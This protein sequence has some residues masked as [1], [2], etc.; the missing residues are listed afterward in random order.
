MNNRLL[1]VISS[2]SGGGKTTICKKLLSESASPLYGNLRF[3]ISATTRKMRTGEVDGEDYHFL[4]L[5]E[6]NKKLE[7]GEFIEHA[8]VF[9][10][11]YGTLLSEVNCKEHVIFDIDVAGF[12]QIREKIA[13]V[14]VFLMP[15]SMDVLRQRLIKRGDVSLEEIEKR[16]KIAQ[17]EVKQAH[18]YDFIIVNN[19]PERTFNSICDFLSSEIIKAEHLS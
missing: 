10:N 13:V 18:E 9:G 17:Q 14:S 11:M 7:N 8:N 3:S 19:D 2:P 1:I 5:E 15:P 4:T 16:L 12:K 6:F